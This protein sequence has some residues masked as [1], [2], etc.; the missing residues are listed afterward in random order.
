MH[1]L[2]HRDGRRRIN[3]ARRRVDPSLSV[4]ASLGVNLYQC[5]SR[6]ISIQANEDNLNNRLN[7]IDFGRLFPK[8]L[9]FRAQCCAAFECK[10][11]G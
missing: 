3:F 7:V 2:T 10:L 9:Q 6:R 1:G 8:R 11:L 4:N 5:E